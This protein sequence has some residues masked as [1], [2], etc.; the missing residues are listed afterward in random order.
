MDARFKILK[1]CRKK[2]RFPFVTDEM[3]LFI[4]DPE[5]IDLQNLMSISERVEFFRT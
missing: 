5:L 2:K 3:L 1:E 4:T